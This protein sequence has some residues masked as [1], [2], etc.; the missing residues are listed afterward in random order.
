MIMYLNAFVDMLQDLFE[1]LFG[2]L[3]EPMLIRVFNTVFMLVK[4]LLWPI[5]TELLFMLLSW[6]LTLLDWF[7]VAFDILTGTREIYQGDKALYLVNL[8]LENNTVQK[9]VIYLSLFSFGLSLLF[10]IFAVMKSIHTSVINE[11]EHVPVGKVLRQAMEGCMHF[12]LVP[13]MVII[14]MKLSTVV[15]I[16]LNMAVSNSS[17]GITPTIGTLIFL[18]NSMDAAKSKEAKQYDREL[19]S[20][21]KAIYGGELPAGY[22]KAYINSPSMFDTLRFSYYAGDKH[23]SDISVV[24]EDFEV[25]K[26]HII[27]AYASAIL[28]LVV[29]MISALMAVRGLIE[30]VI[31]YLAAHLTISTY[32]L[33]GGKMYKNWLGTFTGRAVFCYGMVLSMKIFLML[34]PTIM[35]P[36]VKFYLTNQEVREGGLGYN[37]IFNSLAETLFPTSGDGGAATKWLDT[38]QGNVST[39]MDFLIRTFIIVGG[40]YSV[41]KAQHLILEIVAEAFSTGI[42][43]A[44]A[45]FGG[46]IM[47]GMWSGIKTAKAG[48]KAL[49]AA[50]KGE[51]PNGNKKPKRD[52][53]G[54]GG[55]N[56]ENAAHEENDQDQGF[57][58]GD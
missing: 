44:T 26:Y 19:L 23:Y 12:L 11:R 41:F 24:M 39:T 5:I 53:E 27:S 21:A 9:V 38:F 31:L 8:F 20:K 18:A 43:D 25:D 17:G 49:A 56:G 46:N 30:V 10:S 22:T 55:A 29:M 57:R 42:K 28:V 47:G 15:L 1:T 2:I 51:G 16:Q 50:S 6:V 52:G 36:N 32:P 58:G 14:V 13:F 37:G 48:V 54:N 45:S 34:T 4:N 40:A 3:I 33:D 7:E 35:T